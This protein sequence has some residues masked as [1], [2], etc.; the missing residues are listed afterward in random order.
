MQKSTFHEMLRPAVCFFL[1]RTRLLS[2]TS[3][4][5][6][7]QITLN[8]PAGWASACTLAQFVPLQMSEPWHDSKPER[9]T[10]C[11]GNRR[12]QG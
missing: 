7:I 6:V 1:M 9:R 12:V 2:R 3:M 5:T 10:G 8:T 11:R 4:V